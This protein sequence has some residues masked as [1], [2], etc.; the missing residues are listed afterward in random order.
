MRW[1]LCAVVWVA[2]MA[3]ALYVASKTRIGPL[4]VQ[5]SQNHGVH[6]GDVLAVVAAVVVGVAVTAIAWFTRPRKPEAGTRPT[7]TASAATPTH[8]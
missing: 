3:C 8:H 7:P 2:G 1:V 4:V 6:V 5:L